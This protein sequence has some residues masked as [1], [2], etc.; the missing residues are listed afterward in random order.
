MGGYNRVGGVQSEIFLPVWYFFTDSPYMGV[1]QPRPI[2][3]GGK[4]PSVPLLTV[5]AIII[6]S[7]NYQV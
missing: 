2:G 6:G 4:L 7:I 3:Y 5:K 1:I